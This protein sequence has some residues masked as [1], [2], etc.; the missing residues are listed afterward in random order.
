MARHRKLLDGVI[1]VDRPLVLIVVIL[2]IHVKLT[3]Y[4]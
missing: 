4:R 3:V 1:E 2:G